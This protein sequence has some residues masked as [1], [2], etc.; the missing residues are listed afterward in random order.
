MKGSIAHLLALIHT[1]YIITNFI[2]ECYAVHRV[3]Y[4]T[5]TEP[6]SY[7]RSQRHVLIGG[8]SIGTCMVSEEEM[9][10]YF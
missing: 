2:T 9:D 6:V 3:S 8:G 5:S 7:L 4:D 1:L 10:H